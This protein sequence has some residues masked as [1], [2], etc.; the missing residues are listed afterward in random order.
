MADKKSVAEELREQ[1]FNVSKSA[2]ERMSEEEIAK[3]L[4]NMSDEDLFG[5]FAMILREQVKAQ[6]AAQIQQQMAG[7]QPAQLIGALNMEMETYSTEQC[8]I[9]YDEIVEFS[10]A[11][12]EGNLQLLGYLDL[13]DPSAIH[14][15][16][17]TFENK[18]RVKVKNSNKVNIF[19]IIT[20]IDNKIAGFAMQ[21]PLF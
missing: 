13:D 6:Y 8:A 14:F 18:P 11:T 15:Y 2:A 1:L 20:P 7:M 9:Y 5:T 16:A 10:D 19:F 4:G 12:Y 17:S 3:Y 21:N